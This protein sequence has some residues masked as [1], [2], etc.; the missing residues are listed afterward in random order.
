MRW[1]RRV[2]RRYD[3]G[4]LDM[5]AGSGDMAV[6]DL[7][8]GATAARG[9]ELVK[10]LL[11][12]GSCHT[13]PD[14]M[15]NPSTNPA[16]FLAGGKRFTVNL[17]GDAGTATVY[18][19]N[20]TPDNTTGVGSWSDQQ[21]ADAITVGVDNQG[22]R[23]GRRCPI[24]ASPRSRSRTRRR[25]RSTCSRCRRE[26]RGAARTRATGAG[27]A[28]FDFTSMPHTTLG[29]TDPGSP[30]RSAGAISATSAACNATRR[31]ARRRSGS[32][33]AKSFAG[34]RTFGGGSSREPDAGRDRPG[35]LDRRRHR[36]TLQTNLEKGTG[37]M[38]AAPCRA[39]R[40]PP[41]RARDS[42]LDDLAQF[43]HTL[44]PVVNGPF[45]PP[46]HVARR[47]VRVAA[48]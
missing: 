37:V 13:T 6:P 22:A 45:M 23:C 1:R 33:S 42:D 20:L 5:Q 19:P 25:S 4:R 12:C 26:S 31:R 14:A 21:I 35:G 10:H 8:A 36:A 46:R 48:A 34:G 38:L 9:E 16:D 15:G 29:A 2:R 11:F 24:S 18:A 30:R 41:R 32:T 39:G 43:V 40:G 47:P 17:G 28:A 3:R 7:G 44:P 27:G